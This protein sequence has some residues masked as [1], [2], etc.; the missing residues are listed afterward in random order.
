MVFSQHVESVDG[1]GSAV[2]KITIEKLTYIGQSRD[3]VV[4]DFDS[5][6]AADANSPLARL[7]G[8]SYKL[9]MSP[10]GRVLAIDD[11]RPI[12]AA[13]A[14]N[15]PANQTAQKLLSDE[16][17]E[18]RHGVTAL[19]AAQGRTVHE[20]DTWN[21]VKVVSFGS[22]G[23]DTLNQIYKLAAIDRADGRRVAVIEMEGIPSAAMA[24]QLH[25]QGGAS[26]SPGV[27][28]NAQE[29]KGSLRL[30]LTNQ[31]IDEYSED[32]TKE[33]VTVLPTQVSGGGFVAMRM[34]ATERY[35]LERVE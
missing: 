16:A 4:L 30:D 18:E 31:R 33:W 9:T 2:L 20:G 7:I 15:Q 24:Q 29:D 22:M 5:S 17:I 32:Q 8:Q 35:K 10:T 13:V 23:T 6:R 21:D 11:V 27:L 3:K 12:R 19:I 1:Q 28:E 26:P 25:E 34:T 14:G